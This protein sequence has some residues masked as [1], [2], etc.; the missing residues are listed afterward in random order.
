[1]GLVGIEPTT[2]R[3]KAGSSA[4]ELQSHENRM[5]ALRLSRIICVPPVKMKALRDPSGRVELPMGFHPLVYKTSAI[6][7]C[8]EGIKTVAKIKSVL[9]FSRRGRTRT[10]ELHLVRMAPL[11][12]GTTRPKINY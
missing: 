1:M 10:D 4:T 7:L 3:V 6:P 8:D 12:L 11:P 9:I 2:L 5:L